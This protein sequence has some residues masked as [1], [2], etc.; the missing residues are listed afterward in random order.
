MRVTVHLPDSLGQAARTMAENQRVSV[1]RLTALA[2]E[3]Y[4]TE[5]QRKRLGN[6]VLRLAGRGLVSDDAFDEIERGRA[7]DRS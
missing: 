3:H 7:D 5:I 6:A 1:S 4:L 2:L